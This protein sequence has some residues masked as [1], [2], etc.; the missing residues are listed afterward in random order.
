MKK[1][2]TKKQAVQLTPKQYIQQRARTLPIAEC[3]INSDW[4]KSKMASILVSRK[5][6]QGNYTTGIFLVDLLTLGIKDAFYHFNKHEDEYKELID[7]FNQQECEKVKYELVHNI[8][9]GAEDFFEEIGILPHPEFNIVQYILEE[10]T[11]DIEFIDIE[12]G[13]ISPSKLSH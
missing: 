11:E 2:K 9:Y 4:D 1:R 6:K 13:D 10:D 5:H 3:W 8:I 12:F 7:K